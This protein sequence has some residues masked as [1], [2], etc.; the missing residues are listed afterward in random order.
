MDDILRKDNIKKETEELN[1]A[2]FCY[3]CANTARNVHIRLQYKYNPVYP[4]DNYVVS[5]VYPSMDITTCF[6]V[7]LIL[8]ADTNI[9]LLYSAYKLLR[10]YRVGRPRFCQRSSLLR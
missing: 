3:E 10:N 8:R 6:G 7:K 1:L 2:L 4:L 5:Y 9:G